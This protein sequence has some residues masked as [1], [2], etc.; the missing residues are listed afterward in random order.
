MASRIDGKLDM[1]LMVGQPLGYRNNFFQ[2]L[3]LLPLLTGIG[4][5]APSI[6]A[7]RAMLGYWYLDWP[8][9]IATSSITAFIDGKK[10]SC[11]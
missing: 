9:I 5:C 10:P 6:G 3:G 11:T 7:A 8:V 2:S 4:H 1:A